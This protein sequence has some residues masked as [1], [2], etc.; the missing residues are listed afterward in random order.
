MPVVADADGTNARTL[1]GV[2]GEINPAWSPDGRLI[3]VVNDLGPVGYIDLIDPDGQRD[4]TRIET[5]V[6]A[7]PGIA[8]QS[9]P[10]RWQR[11]AP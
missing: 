3:A 8:D 7:D 11:L 2:Y 1:P 6:P 9:S 5:V 4:P 10:V